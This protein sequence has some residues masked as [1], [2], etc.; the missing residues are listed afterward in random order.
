[1]PPRVRAVHDGPAAL[2]AARALPPELMLIDIGLP[3]MNGYEVARALRRDAALK[4]TTLV[5]LTG[6]GRE[7]D[8]QQAIMAGFD[9]H[10]VKPV[11]PNVLSKL[12]ARIANG[13][14][15]ASSA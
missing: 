10:V 4:D 8:R 2:D 7:E 1:M 13:A 9:Y 11:E 12:L 15:L 14:A 6:Y 3:G 5:A